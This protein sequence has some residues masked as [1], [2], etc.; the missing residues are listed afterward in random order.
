MEEYECAICGEIATKGTFDFPLC[1]YHYEKLKK[2]GNQKKYYMYL[3]AKQ[4]D[5]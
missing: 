2:I 3:F 1:E 5:R 4:E